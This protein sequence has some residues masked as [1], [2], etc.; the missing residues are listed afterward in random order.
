MGWSD[1]IPFWCGRQ[2][3]FSI[4]LKTAML[5]HFGI[6]IKTLGGLETRYHWETL[7]FLFE[8]K[9]HSYFR[10]KICSWK[11]KHVTYILDISFIK[12]NQPNYWII[13]LTL[14]ISIQLCVFAYFCRL[15]RFWLKSIYYVQYTLIHILIQGS[16]RFTTQ[17][18]QSIN[19]F[20]GTTGVQHI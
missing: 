12:Q 3:L 5:W 18:Y 16:H 17:E 19:Y 1:L 14:L 2:N 15:C 4:W 20:T 7:L 9:I 11:P 10:S 6:S 8:N 13:I